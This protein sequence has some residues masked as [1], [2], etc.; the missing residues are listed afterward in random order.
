MH[1]HKLPHSPCN[2]FF[3]SSFSLSLSLCLSLSQDRHNGNL[4]IDNLGHAIHIDYGF[5]LGISPGG[6]MGF[7]TAAF[8]I[9][10][11]MVALMGGQGGEVYRQFEDLVVRGFLV[12]RSVCCE[13]VDVVAALA[14]SGLPC[15]LHKEDN[16]E[17]LRGRFMPELTAT[18]AAKC[19]RLKVADA[20]DKWTTKAYDG[21]QKLQN[22]I[23]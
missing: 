22:N 8:K 1:Y 17:R 6:N 2:F 10:A 15:F 9:T 20:A 13:V 3:F 16:L 12:A 19:M 23:Y 4:L 5:I 14:D 21:I 7:E 11:D 18:E